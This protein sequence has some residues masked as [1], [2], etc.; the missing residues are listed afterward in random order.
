MDYAGIINKNEMMRRA[1]EFINNNL[2]DVDITM[3]KII[4]LL[5]EAGMRFNLSPFDCIVLEHFYKNKIGK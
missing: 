3:Q 2:D 5:D 1:I 4:P